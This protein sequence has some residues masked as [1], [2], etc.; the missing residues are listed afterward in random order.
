VSGSPVVL[1]TSVGEATGTRAA[2]AALAC[3][4]PDGDSAR[5]LVELGAAA[6]RPSLLA[7]AA[8]R[9]LEERL[10]A[11][12]PQAAVS[13]HGCICRL[14]LPGDEAGVGQIAAALPLARGGLAVV[15]PPAALLQP[16][17]AEARLRPS[18]TMLRAD[19]ARDRSLTALVCGDLI[20]RG[21]PVA[22]LK[23]P[24]GWLPAQ[25]AQLGVPPFAGSGLPGWVVR[26]LLREGGGANAGR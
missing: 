14:V 9:E 17:L 10:A 7:T 18:A 19:L 21:L 12:M 22:V 2:A 16:A 26:R 25:L 1:V 4:G 24:L 15:R 20:A 3:A 8:A 23:E 6:R 13:S 11:H 5:L